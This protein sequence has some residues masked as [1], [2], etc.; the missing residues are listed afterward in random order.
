VAPPRLPVPPAG[1][2]SEY[3]QRPAPEVFTP[4]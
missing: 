2:G 4:F 1:T 3:L